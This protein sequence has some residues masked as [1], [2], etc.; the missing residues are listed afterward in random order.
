MLKGAGKPEANCQ[1]PLI[2]VDIWS[3]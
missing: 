3:F 2:S 1:G